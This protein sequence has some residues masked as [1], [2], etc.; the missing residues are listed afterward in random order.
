[1]EVDAG[2]LASLAIQGAGASMTTLQPGTANAFLL[3]YW[4]LCHR[5]RPEH[6]GIRIAVVAGTYAKSPTTV[7]TLADHY[8][9]EDKGVNGGAVSTDLGF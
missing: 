8:F 7:V 9:G 2:S 5:Q 1:M 4:G 6:R 3:A